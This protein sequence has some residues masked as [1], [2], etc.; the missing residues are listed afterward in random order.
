MKILEV[1]TKKR[2]IGN[3]GE[4]AATKFLRKKKYKILERNYV[5]LGHEIDIIAESSDAIIFVEVKTRTAG[6]E[7]P[8]ETRPSASVTPQ[9]QQ[10]ILKTAA[11][12]FNY[13]S[14]GKRAQFDVIEVF[15]SEKNGRSVVDKIV[16]LERTFN[17]NTAYRR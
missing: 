16:H 17:K 12:Y 6:K 8:R 9:K 13:N 15:L 7:N 14:K 10:A 5:A 4:D 1:L 2:K 11:Y 3:I